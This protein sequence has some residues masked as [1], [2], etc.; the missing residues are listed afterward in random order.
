MFADALK[1]GRSFTMP[2]LFITEQPDLQNTGQSLYSL[3]KVILFVQ[4]CFFMVPL[5]NI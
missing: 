2:G 5:I 4:A 3:K 1:I